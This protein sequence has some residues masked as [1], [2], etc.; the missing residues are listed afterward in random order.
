MP[1]FVWLLI[2]AV[3]IAT[4]AAFYVREK[5]SGRNE[6][7]DFDRHQHD[8]AGEAGINADMRGP[9]GPSSTLMG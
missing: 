3:V 2:W 4:V 7:A 6:V 1:A 5:R 8:A 9:N